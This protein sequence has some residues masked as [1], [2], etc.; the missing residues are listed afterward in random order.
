[1]IMIII[2]MIIQEGDLCLEEKTLNRIVSGLHTSITVHTCRNY[3]LQEE[4]IL[5]GKPAVWGPNI[6]V[7]SPSPLMGPNIRL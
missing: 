6:Q 5:R 4:D 1:M 7:I 3:L 2:M